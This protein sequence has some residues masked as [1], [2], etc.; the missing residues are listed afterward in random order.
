MR[1]AYRDV[2]D[3]ALDRNCTLREAAYALALGRINDAL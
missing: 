3:F 1:D 2:A